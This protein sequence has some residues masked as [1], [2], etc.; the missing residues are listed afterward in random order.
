[1]DSPVHGDYLELTRGQ[2]KGTVPLRIVGINRPRRLPYY[3]SQQWGA[4]NTVRYGSHV[5]NVFSW[6]ADRH[7]LPKKYH[8]QWI[9]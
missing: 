4:V 8:P 3:S 6:A 1:M 2:S 9:I 5:I 7:D